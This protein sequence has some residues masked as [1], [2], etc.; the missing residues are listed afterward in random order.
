MGWKLGRFGANVTLVTCLFF[1]T[2]YATERKDV[3]DAQQIF[4]CSKELMQEEIDSTVW[5][6]ALFAHNKLFER[7]IYQLAIR[8][9]NYSD[10]RFFEHFPTLHAGEIRSLLQHPDSLGLMQQALKVLIRHKMG[11]NPRL[12][13]WTQG[14]VH[15]PWNPKDPMQAGNDLTQIR[16]LGIIAYRLLSQEHVDQLEVSYESAYERGEVALRLE[17]KASFIDARTE[18]NAILALFAWMATIE[19]RDTTVR[20]FAIRALLDAAKQDNQAKILVNLLKL[21]PEMLQFQSPF[22][23][24]EDE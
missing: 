13:E 7:Q 23:L 14:Q 2:F 11:W 22:D 21:D 6:G 3:E 16:M 1:N 12:I 17:D 10:L 24:E 9:Q 5:R 18:A 19:E 8:Q 20:P 4:T 15:F